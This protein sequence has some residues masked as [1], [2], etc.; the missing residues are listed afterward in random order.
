MLS[1]GERASWLS[2]AYHRLCRS[3]FDL[4]ADCF[5]AV[6][7]LRPLVDKVI[8]KNR[9][10]SRRPTSTTSIL[11]SHVGQEGV[12]FVRLAVNVSNNVVCHL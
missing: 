1:Y 12:K 5:D 9:G 10:L 3:G 6:K 11:V 7:L 2:A 4:T 8:R